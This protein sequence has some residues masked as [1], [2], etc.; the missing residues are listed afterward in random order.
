MTDEKCMFIDIIKEDIS[1]LN[2]EKLKDNVY[3][4]QKS[5]AQISV[6][7]EKMDVTIEKLTDLLSNVT[8]LLTV[9]EQ[10]LI[11][12]DQNKERLNE[13]VNQHRAENNDKIK[14]IY[15]V[16]EKKHDDLIDK[17]EI[18]SDKIEN[19]ITSMQKYIWLGLGGVG[20]A[21]WI[22][23]YGAIA[24]SLITKVH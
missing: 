14:E 3:D 16:V 19:K 4:L 21:I 1:K 12:F 11:Q 8:N 24:V 23:Q 15:T 5:M 7:V 22:M 18:F 13:T 10:R 17:F 9:H 20:V 6:L 2:I